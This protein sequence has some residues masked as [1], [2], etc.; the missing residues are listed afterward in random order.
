VLET[1]LEAKQQFKASHIIHILTGKAITQIK[2]YKHHLL[3]SFGAGSEKD[4]RFWNMV[5]RQSL[6]NLLINKDIENYGLLKVSEKA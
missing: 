5:I 1:I 4:E 3:S 6:I 2:Q